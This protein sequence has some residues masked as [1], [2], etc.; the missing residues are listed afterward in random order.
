MCHGR[1]TR[2]G[3]RTRKVLGQTAKY[4]MGFKL[5]SID[6][7]LI[8]RCFH[9][10]GCML[11]NE[12]RPSRTRNHTAANVA[13]GSKATRRA[14]CATE[15]QPP[16][17]ARFQ[18]LNPMGITPDCNVLGTYQDMHTRLCIFTSTGI[19]NILKLCKCRHLG[20]ATR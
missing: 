5:P 8:S 9:R 10:S 13:R 2:W 15:T 14:L 1:R 17:Y 3:R 4:G 12:G 6:A 16:D 19:I 11:A 20:V 18:A 7:Y